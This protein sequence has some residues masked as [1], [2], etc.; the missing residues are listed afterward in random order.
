MRVDEGCLVVDVPGRH[1]IRLPL[2]GEEHAARLVLYRLPRE[3]GVVY[4]VAVLNAGGE[5]MLDS[6]GAR[7]RHLVEAFAADAA[8]T[9]ENLPYASEREGRAHLE[10]RARRWHSTADVGLPVRGDHSPHEV[11]LRLRPYDEVSGELRPCEGALEGTPCPA[12]TLGWDGRTL[13][14][15]DPVAGRALRLMPASLYHYRYERRVLVSGKEETR[16]LTGL[17]LLDADGLVLADLP[18]EWPAHEVAVFAAGRRLP[19]HDALVAPSKVVRARLS[20]RAPSWRTRTASPRG[21]GSASRSVRWA[22]RSISTS[23]PALTTPYPD[24]HDAGT[25]VRLDARCL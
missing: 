1:P 24:A 13:V 22:V 3:N 19:V 20:R 17:A 21:A 8:L 14:A 7:P 18:G 23:P 15:T 10:T 11:A 12:T 4:G 9:F 5:V 6:P 2:T 16:S 25:G